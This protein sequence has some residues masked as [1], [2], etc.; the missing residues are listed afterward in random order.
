MRR[1]LEVTLSGAT[2]SGGVLKLLP[3]KVL[4]D[5]ERRA[6]QGR[7]STLRR[8]LEHRDRAQARTTL[9]AFLAS[10]GSN[11][12]SEADAEMQIAS[13]LA[14]MGDMPPWAIAEA[15]R[16]CTRGGYGAEASAFAPSAA[17]FHEV[18]A[19]VLQPYAAE[20]EQLET[21]LSARETPISAAERERVIAGFDA[22]VSDVGGRPTEGQR[23]ESARL[24]Y[25]AMCAEAGVSPEAIPDA[26][27]RDGT[28]RRLTPT[29]A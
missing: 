5:S 8:S 19:R 6:M 20:A 15:A 10:Y 12:G 11:R 9:V 14:V 1:L 13:Y 23:A 7:L 2:R 24:R 28:F 3:G 22:L 17:Q 29:T 27:P 21:A 18:A 16:A 4:D 25:E 26:P